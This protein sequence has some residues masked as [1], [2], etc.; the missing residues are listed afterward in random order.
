MSYGQEEFHQMRKK[1]MSWSYMHHVYC[2]HETYLRHEEVFIYINITKNYKCK[3]IED[4][5]SC[6][7]HDG[8]W[9]RINKGLTA[10]NH[11]SEKSKHESWHRGTECDREGQVNIWVQDIN[12]AMKR[13]IALSVDIYWIEKSRWHG[14]EDKPWLNKSKKSI[15]TSSRQSCSSQE[16]VNILKLR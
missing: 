10:M 13:H 9:R 15:V 7:D 2:C 3:L 1:R 12:Y 16:H 8:D 5:K 6:V 11:T 14:Q 4:I